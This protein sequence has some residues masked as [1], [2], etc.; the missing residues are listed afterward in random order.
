MPA[1]G[2]ILAPGATLPKTGAEGAVLG[3]PARLESDQMRLSTHLSL[4]LAQVE[5]EG[6]TIC[7][8]RNELSTQYSAKGRT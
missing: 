7:I 2:A 3:P 5:L 8:I 4:L 1:A 6:D